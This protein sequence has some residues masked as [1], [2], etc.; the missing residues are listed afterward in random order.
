MSEIKGC[1]T[2]LE[3]VSTS[4]CVKWTVKNFESLASKPGDHVKS[5]IFSDAAKQTRWR[6]VLYPGGEDQ[7]S[8][9]Y[10]SVYLELVSDKT[11]WAKYEIQV[12][13]SDGHNFIGAQ[14]NT[15]FESNRI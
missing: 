8:K 15:E 5:C 9:S 2:H 10:I 11:V 12:L 14:G 4:F 3:S 7:E 13:S 6:L 1:E